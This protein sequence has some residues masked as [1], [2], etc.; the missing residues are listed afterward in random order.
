MRGR[1]PK[2]SELI[3]EPG[4]AELA[5]HGGRLYPKA[6]LRILEYQPVAMRPNHDA[7]TAADVVHVI[8]ASWLGRAK[9]RPKVFPGPAREAVDALV[10]FAVCGSLWDVLFGARS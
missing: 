8:P 3:A 6:S 5:G 10:G 4:F 2:R 7:K 1:S 9:G